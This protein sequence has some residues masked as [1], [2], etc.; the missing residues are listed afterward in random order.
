MGHNKLIAVSAA[1][2]FHLVAA[3]SA[4]SVRHLAS[5]GA[6]APPTSIYVSSDPQL[7][8][9]MMDQSVQH[10]YVTSDV[11]MDPLRWSSPVAINRSLVI[12]GI[13]AGAYP[14]LDRSFL[15]KKWILGAGVNLTH[16]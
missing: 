3:A 11:K 8:S 12:E 15:A 10:I 9:A 5:S 7:W 4:V 16:K 6:H 1:L 14:V 13:P 2:L